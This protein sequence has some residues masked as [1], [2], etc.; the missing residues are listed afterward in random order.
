MIG[1][2]IANFVKKSIQTFFK[3]FELSGSKIVSQIAFF[4]LL[5]IISITVLNQAGINIEI[6]TNNLNLIL[7]AFLVSV[8]LAIGLVSRNIVADLLRTFYSRRKYE[9]GQKIKFK[10]IQGEIISV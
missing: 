8:A 4:I 7:S 2:F 9:I 6:I 5:T 10:N 3:S 1:L